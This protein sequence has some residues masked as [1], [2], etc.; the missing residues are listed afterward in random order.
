MVTLVARTQ[1]GQAAQDQ[2]KESERMGLGVSPVGNGKK[3]GNRAD[4]SAGFQGE[5]Q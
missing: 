5:V 1:A 4:R 2:R 3:V